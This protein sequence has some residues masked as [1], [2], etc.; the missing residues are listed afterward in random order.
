[1]GAGVI[2]ALSLPAR[3]TAVDGAIPE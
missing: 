1:V 3:T 2:F